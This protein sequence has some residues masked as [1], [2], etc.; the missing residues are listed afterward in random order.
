MEVKVNDIP[1]SLTPLTVSSCLQYQI[2]RMQYVLQAY[3][4]DLRFILLFPEWKNEFYL[5]NDTD[6]AHKNKNRKDTG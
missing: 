3:M 6:I 4:E 1:G 2:I 5:L